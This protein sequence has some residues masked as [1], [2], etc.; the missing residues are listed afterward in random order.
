MI[1]GFHHD[2]NQIF[3]FQYL[4]LLVEKCSERGKSATQPQLKNTH[5]TFRSDV[6]EA[7]N[8]AWNDG[9]C[10]SWYKMSSAEDGIERA[11]GRYIQ[12]A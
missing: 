6:T 5:I 10:G 7:W 2:A 8:V 11:P 9:G 1:S 3:G 12:V 4:K